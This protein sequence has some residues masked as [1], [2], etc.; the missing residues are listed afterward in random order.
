MNKLVSAIINSPLVKNILLGQVRHYVGLLGI[1]LV[2]DGLLDNSQATQMTGAI[3]VIVPLALSAYDKWQA[4]QAKNAA[5]LAA[6]QKKEN[7]Q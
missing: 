2:K 3:M 7:A 6:A 5:I 1:W 4:I